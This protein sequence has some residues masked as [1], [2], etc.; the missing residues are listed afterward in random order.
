MILLS[1]SSYD[2][3]DLYSQPTL[4]HSLRHRDSGG[5]E[6]SNLALING[7][8]QVMPISLTP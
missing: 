1:S 8:N 3:L 6:R 2:R 5:M 7:R 4:N